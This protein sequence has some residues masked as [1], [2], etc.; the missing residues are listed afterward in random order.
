MAGMAQSETIIAINQDED[1]Q[2]FDASPLR[3][4]RRSYEIVPALIKAIS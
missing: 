1:A 3:C 2:I 4:G